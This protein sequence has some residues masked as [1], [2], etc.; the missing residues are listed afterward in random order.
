MVCAVSRSDSP[1]VVEDVLASREMTSAESRL[2]AM[3]NAMR[4]RVLGSRKRLTMVLP[5]RAGTFFTLRLRI[6]LKSHGGVVN[7]IDLFAGE[8]FEG[9]EVAAIPGHQK[10][11][12]GRIR[13]GAKPS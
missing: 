2:A 11:G 13:I 5:R 4:V 8:F 7:L 12:A 9:E 1:L 3:S 10:E 6:F